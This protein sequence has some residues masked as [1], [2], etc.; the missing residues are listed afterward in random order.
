MSYDLSEFRDDFDKI[1]VLHI[2]ALNLTTK[3][4]GFGIL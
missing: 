4:L 1:R 3:N 2:W